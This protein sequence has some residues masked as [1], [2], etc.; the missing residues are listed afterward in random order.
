MGI[1]SEVAE[2]VMMIMS[3]MAFQCQWRHPES[4]VH[5]V[6]IR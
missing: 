6:M 5:G 2:S 1:G 3:L 4:G